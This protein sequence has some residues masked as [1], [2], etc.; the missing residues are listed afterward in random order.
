V[1]GGL[2]YVETFYIQ[3]QASS[4]SFPQLNRVLVWYADRVGVGQ[5]LQQSLTRAVQ[6]APVQTPAVGAGVGATGTGPA[7]PT[8]TTPPTRTTAPP[9]RTTA[10]PPADQAAALAGLNA[11]ANVL[12]AAK[13]SGDLGQIGAASQQLQDAVNA[14]LAMA[15]TT[16]PSATSA[17][18]G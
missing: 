3:G 18:G 6:S 12:D 15:G 7:T 1:N 8:T 4:T 13:A 2:L 10:P 17:A 5:T 16:I 9:T 14:Y 11:A